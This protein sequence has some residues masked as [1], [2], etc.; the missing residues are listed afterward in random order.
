MRR[1]FAV[2][3]TLAVALPLALFAAGQL[4][5]L[6]GTPPT[7]LGVRD[8]RLKPPAATPNSV[9]SQAALYPGHPRSAQA[10]IDPL[11][12]VDG[13]PRATIARLDALLAA[14]GDAHVVERR[15]DYLRVEF[16]TRWLRFVDD[17]EFWADPAAGVVQ[18]RSASRLG[19][20]DLGT[21]RRRIEALRAQLATAERPRAPGG[22]AGADGSQGAGR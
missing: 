16:T 3:G 14:R 2:L 10:G 12:A 15:A 13:D 4:G 7:D 19:E 11:P 6:A 21:N 20:S 9:S 8:G 5:L 18:V 17:A 22:T 1:A